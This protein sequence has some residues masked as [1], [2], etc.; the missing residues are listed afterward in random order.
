VLIAVLGLAATAGR[1]QA[2][3]LLLAYGLGRAVPLLAIGFSSDLATRFLA[4]PGARSWAEAGRTA[5]GVLILALAGYFLYLG[6]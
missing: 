3:S 2:V 4:R 6:F 1:S 5:L